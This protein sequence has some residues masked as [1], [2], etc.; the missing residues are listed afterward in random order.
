MKSVQQIEHEIEVSTRRLG[1]LLPGAKYCS[2]ECM[3]PENNPRK[4]KYQIQIETHSGDRIF[5]PRQGHHL[6]GHEILARVEGFESRFELARR[7]HRPLIDAAEQICGQ[8]H[9]GCLS[10]DVKGIEW[11]AVEEL[12]SQVTRLA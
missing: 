8:A 12:R 1:L 5:I 2:W 6:L 10:T 11:D 7:M 9:D 3:D 4:R